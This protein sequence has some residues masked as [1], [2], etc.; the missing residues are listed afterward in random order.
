MILVLYYLYVLYTLHYGHVK[1]ILGE[2]PLSRSP[3]SLR[4]K[5]FIWIPK[6]ILNEHKDLL[7]T[8]ATN[9][10][11]TF[12]IYFRSL[13]LLIIVSTINIL[14]CILLSF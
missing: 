12:E 3:T 11:P 14:L 8:A 9:Y 1:S 7:A 4:D 13:I 5:F 2:K 6:F 10:I